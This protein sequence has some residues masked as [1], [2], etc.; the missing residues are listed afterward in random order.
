MD[1]YYRNVP[2]ESL[3]NWSKQLYLPG[4]EILVIVVFCVEVDLK[5]AIQGY[6]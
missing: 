1:R 6:H 3:R 5:I 4:H 2:A